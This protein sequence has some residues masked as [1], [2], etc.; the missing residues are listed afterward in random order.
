MPDE[1]AATLD[2]KILIG[3]GRFFCTSIRSSRKQRFAPASVRSEKASITDVIV[4]VFWQRVVSEVPYQKPFPFDGGRDRG[5]K[6]ITPT[7]ILPRREGGH[8]NETGLQVLM[9]AANLELS[10]AAFFFVGSFLVLFVPLLSAQEKKLDP[11]TI[12]YASV[13][14]TRGPLWIAQDVG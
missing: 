1:V 8:W 13:S 3:P 10:L 9:L 11:F 2:W 7:L 5:A 12:S 6:K 4:K 14:G